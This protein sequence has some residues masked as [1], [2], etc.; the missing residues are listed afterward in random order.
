MRSLIA[1]LAVASLIATPAPLAMA[2][3]PATAAERSVEVAV[4]YNLNIP[5]TAEDEKNQTAALE[6]ARKTLYEIAAGECAVMLQTLAASCHLQ[7]LNVQ[8]SIQ[9]RDSNQM[10]SVVVA[11]NASYRIGLK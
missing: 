2:Q 11:G 5:M 3:A 1:A 6:R 4:S 7:R 9:R 10:P 8:S